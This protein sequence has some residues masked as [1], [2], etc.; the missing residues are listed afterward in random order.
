[1][2]RFKDL[3]L[4]VILFFVVSC[5]TLPPEVVRNANYGAYPRNYEDKIKSMIEPVLKDP[6]SAHYNFRTPHK[7]YAVDGLIGGNKEYFG[8][9]V[10]VGVNAK[11]SFG[12]YTGERLYTFFMYNG[13]IQLLD[14]VSKN[15]V[16][17]VDL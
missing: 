15:R 14:S 13:Q 16:T 12:G 3:F 7:A 2:F 10:D 8:Y 1:M 11:N 5:A 9:C 4:L 6:Y 17:R